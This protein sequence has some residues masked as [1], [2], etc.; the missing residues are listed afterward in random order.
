M[1]II[2][3]VEAKI[4]NAIVQVETTVLNKIKDLLDPVEALA[5]KIQ[6]EIAAIKDMTNQEKEILLQD[7]KPLV[8]MVALLRS[9]I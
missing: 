2:S 6:T 7:I 8:D 4:E 9:I 1:S 5:T 3:E